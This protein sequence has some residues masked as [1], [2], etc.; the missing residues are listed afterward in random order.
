MPYKKCIC[1]ERYAH[2]TEKMYI[3]QK[4]CTQHGRNVFTTKDMHISRR[5]DTLERCA[6][7]ISKKMIYRIHH[8][9]RINRVEAA[10]P[11][12]TPDWPMSAD[13]RKNPYTGRVIRKAANPCNK[14]KGLRL[15]R[16]K[17]LSLSLSPSLSKTA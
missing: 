12:S 14:T 11:P 9:G 17:S 4:I 16:L 5:I 15:F 13:R 1:R 7:T 8:F 2:C 10:A 3:P 6:M